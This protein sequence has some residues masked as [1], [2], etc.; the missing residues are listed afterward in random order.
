MN[1]DQILENDLGGPGTYYVAI[2]DLDR[3]AHDQEYQLMAVL[4]S[5]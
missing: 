4:R 3:K 2:S 1:L 5:V